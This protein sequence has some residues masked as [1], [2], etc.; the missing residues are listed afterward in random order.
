MKIIQ[1][2]KNGDENWYYLQEK[3]PLQNPLVLVFG[4]RY[5]L[6]DENIIKNIREEF[7]YENIV[8]GSTS[9]EILDG[10]FQDNSI[11]V[12]AI[13]LE[14]TTFV[15]ERENISNFNM[16]SN[17]LGEKLLGKLSK[18]K[19]KHL[20]V[21]SDGLLDGSKLIE[22]LENNLSNTIAITGGLC[23]DDARFEKT[24][25]SFNDNPKTGEVVLIGLYGETLEISYASAGGW[26]PFGPERKITKSKGNIIFEI[27]N[28]PALDVYKN[29]LAHRAIGLPSASLSFPL[30]VTYENKNQAVVRTILD[31]DESQNSLILAGDAPENSKVQLLMA[32]VD[33]IIDG[34]QLATQLAMKNRK[35]KAEIAI[36]VSCI[37]RKF[38][39]NNRVG[40]ETEYVKESLGASTL[41]TG[42]YS[43]GQIAPFDGND[44][45][46]LHNQTMTV[47]LISE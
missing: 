19:L 16:Q 37:G 20:F 9:G 36:L 25:T 43:Y 30:N 8:F 35:K 10:S 11:S 17:L 7:T 31:I 18:E 34:A 13:E 12:T 22:G 1:A 44:Y 4:N 23:G 40:E 14:N 41:I 21:L 28:K 26:F 42:F 15:I 5:L 46:N 38:V 32:S 47:T 24:V 29:H 3:V 33:A 27:D 39:M 45:A 2:F 6:E